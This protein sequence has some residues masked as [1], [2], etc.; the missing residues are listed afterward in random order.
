LIVIRC[1]WWDSTGHNIETR[2]IDPD[3]P[4]LPFRIWL[5]HNHKRNRLINHPEI[6]KLKMQFDRSA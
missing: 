1:E 2:T 6:K 4:E 3:D 5:K